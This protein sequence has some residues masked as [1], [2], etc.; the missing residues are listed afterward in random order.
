MSATA[1]P[2]RGELLGKRIVVTGAARGIGQAIVRAYVRHGA[3]VVAMDVRKDLGESA[4]A[5]ANEQGPGTAV[6]VPADVSSRFEVEQA[7]RCVADRWGA[8]DVLVHAAGVERRCPAED[9]DDTGWDLLFDSNA[10]STMLTNQASFRLMCEGGGRILNFGSDS[11]LAPH[12]EGAHYSAAKAAAMA[13]TRSV[14]HEWGEYGITVNAVLPAI[15]TP[16]YEEYRAR[17]S[18]EELAAHDEKMRVRIPLG[19]G[20]GDA[21]RDLAPVMVFLAGDGARFITGQLI[22]VDGGKCYVR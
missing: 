17:R 10:R 9:I 16:M 22:P 3:Q 19:G 21:D 6:F 8:L 20:L 7:F 2:G 1:D 13:W 11:G 4:T 5:A 18:S 14:A 15:R 12:I